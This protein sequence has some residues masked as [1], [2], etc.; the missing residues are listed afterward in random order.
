MHSSEEMEGWNLLR[1]WN[2]AR[3]TIWLSFVGIREAISFEG[4]G[5][6]TLSSDEKRLELEGK[7]WS[8]TIDLTDVGLDKVVSERLLATLACPETLPESLE[9]WLHTGDRCTLAVRSEIPS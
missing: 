2:I 6:A 3:S 4:L 7:G 9:L 5:T 8:A 1:K